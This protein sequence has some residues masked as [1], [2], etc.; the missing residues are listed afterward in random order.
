MQAPSN[1]WSWEHFPCS[2]WYPSD[3][4]HSRYWRQ[5]YDHEG[6]CCRFEQGNVSSFLPVWRSRPWLTSLAYY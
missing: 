1:S 6:R 3:W 4:G 5:R 2:S